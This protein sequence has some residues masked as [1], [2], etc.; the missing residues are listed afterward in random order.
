M[1]LGLFLLLPAPASQSDREVIDQALWEVDFAE[2]NGLGSVWLAEHH[3]SSFG[4]IGAPSV[5]AAAIAQRTAR[6]EIG[7]AVAVVP[8][9]HPLRLAEEIAWVDQLSGGR[10]LVGIGSGFSP[11]ELAAFD[12]P[13]E[14]RQERLEEGATVLRGLLSGDPFSHRGKHWRVPPVTLRPRPYRGI[15]PPLLRACSSAASLRRAALAGDPAMLGLA[16]LA[17]IAERV[18]LYRQVRAEL[19]RSA[20]E[21]EREIGELRVLRRVSVAPTDE[22]AQEQTRR[23]LAWET[24]TA[25]RVHSPAPGKEG[26]ERHEIDDG[27]DGGPLVGGCIGS[28]ATVRNE[29]AALRALGIRHVIAWVSFGDLPWAQRRRSLELL[30]GEVLPGLASPA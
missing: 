13:F 6:L 5:L 22:E 28:A 29:L 2:A 9:H 1:E 11:F 7:Y 25:Q 18:A 15:A 30:C 4:L 17:E 3:L 19:G 16:P 24:A 23:A 14:E 21:I 20:A 8:L 26:D 10:V 27:E 12:V